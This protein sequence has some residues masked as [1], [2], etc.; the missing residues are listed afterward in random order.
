MNNIWQF[1]QGGIDENE[2]EEEALLRELEEEIGTRE[3]EIIA[4]YAII[5]YFSLS[6]ISVKYLKSRFRFQI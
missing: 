1:P 6:I 2:S 5:G 4:S 3:V